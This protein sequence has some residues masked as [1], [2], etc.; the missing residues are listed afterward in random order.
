MVNAVLVLSLFALWLPAA[1]ATP[2]VL[3]APAMYADAV[4]QEAAVRQ[5]LHAPHVQKTV[6][7]AVRTV[8]AQYEGLVRH[9]PTSGYADDALW[10]AA[11][12]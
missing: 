4:A 5:A 3:P 1:Q 9:Y 6:L 10:R 12:V 8:V 2:T 7:K 11:Q